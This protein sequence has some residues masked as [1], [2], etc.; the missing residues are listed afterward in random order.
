MYWPN[1]AILKNAGDESIR[2]PDGVA[3]PPGKS[4]KIY[5]GSSVW[6]RVSR[7]IT[8]VRETSQIGLQYEYR[9]VYPDLPLFTY[10]FV[11][12]CR[13]CLQTPRCLAKKL[14]SKLY[15]ACTDTCHWLFRQGSRNAGESHCEEQSNTDKAEQHQKSDSCSV[16]STNACD[17]RGREVTITPTKPA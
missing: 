2:L 16:L 10:L 7:S 6:G 11:W 15:L 3:I 17:D 12:R 1:V 13:Q 9:R 8:Y 4:L 5:G 14:F